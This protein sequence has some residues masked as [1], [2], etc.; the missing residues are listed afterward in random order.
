MNLFA[1]WELQ[2]FLLVVDGGA[3]EVV[4]WK[5]WREIAKVRRATAQYAACVFSAK[6]CAKNGTFPP[7]SFKR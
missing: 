2:N 7:P 1:A 6:T 3:Q 4:Q 5:G